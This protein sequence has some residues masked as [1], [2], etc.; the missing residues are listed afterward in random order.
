M[1]LL[2]K[3]N[4]YLQHKYGTDPYSAGSFEFSMPVI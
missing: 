2:L 3:V 1:L 4:C